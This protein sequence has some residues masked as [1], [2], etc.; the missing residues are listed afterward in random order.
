LYEDFNILT[1]PWPTES[2]LRQIRKDLNYDEELNDWWAIGDEKIIT[3]L[4]SLYNNYD[5]LFEE[6][7]EPT[8]LKEFINPHRLPVYNLQKQ[9]IDLRQIKKLKS[10]E[11][12]KGIILSR[13]PIA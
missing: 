12:N 7:K 1:P 3:K 11:G 6:L 10:T 8:L 5:I 4:N 2:A 9:G 13:N